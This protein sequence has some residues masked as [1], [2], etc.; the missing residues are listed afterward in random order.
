MQQP[1]STHA[2]SVASSAPLTSKVKSSLFEH[3]LV[4]SPWLPG[5]IHLGTAVLIILTM[6]GLFPERSCIPPILPFVVIPNS[7]SK[8]VLNLLSTHFTDMIFFVS[9][10]PSALLR[11]YLSSFLPLYFGTFQ[12]K[13]PVLGALAP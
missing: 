13:M 5:Y 3:D 12:D 7:L 6:P 1:H 10:F 8:A 4:R 11:I 2:H 9:F